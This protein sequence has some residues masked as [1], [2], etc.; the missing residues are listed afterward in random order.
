M[1]YWINSNSGDYVVQDINGHYTLHLISRFTTTEYLM[2]ERIEI[3]PSQFSS[4]KGF[5]PIKYKKLF[6]NRQ[7]KYYAPTLSDG[8]KGESKRVSLPTKA[9]SRE[10]ILKSLGL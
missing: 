4:L 6:R 7:R 1:N 9:D 2:H 3:T 10:E 5:I 8:T